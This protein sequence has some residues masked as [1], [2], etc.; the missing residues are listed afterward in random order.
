MW[1]KLDE[2]NVAGPWMIVGDFNCVLD[3]DERSSGVGQ[4]VASSNGW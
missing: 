1:M 2:M 3:G 4:K